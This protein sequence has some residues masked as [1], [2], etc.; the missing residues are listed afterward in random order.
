MMVII[1]QVINRI[2]KSCGDI[3]EVELAKLGVAL[4]NCQSKSEGRKTYECTDDMVS[5][6]NDSDSLL[7][8]ILTWP[9][10]PAINLASKRS[11]PVLMNQ[12]ASHQVYLSVRQSAFS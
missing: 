5:L 7:C 2:K 10:I 11:V 3:N 1:R 12:I 9:F 4:L 8:P 6:S